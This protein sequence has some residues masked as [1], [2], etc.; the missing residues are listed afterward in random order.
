[1]AA[2]PSE[3]AQQQAHLRGVNENT[4]ASLDHAAREVTILCECGR[5]ECST[6]LTLNSEFYRGIRRQRSWFIVADGHEAAEI[7]RIRERRGRFTIVESTYV[8]SVETLPATS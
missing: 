1:M 2:R 8:G 6:E 7:D 4:A 3:S 5:S